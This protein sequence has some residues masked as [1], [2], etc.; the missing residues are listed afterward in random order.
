MDQAD[1]EHTK[2]FEQK[3]REAHDSAVPPIDPSV[4][5]PRPEFSKPSVKTL[6]K[7]EKVLLATGA[8]GSLGLGAVVIASL[9]ADDSPELAAPRLPTPS[10]DALPVIEGDGDTAAAP[11]ASASPSLAPT[12]A[13][14]ATAPPPAHHTRPVTHH[15]QAAPHDES[16]HSLRQIPDLVPVAQTVTDEMSYGQALSAAR[17]E[18][19]PGGLFVWNDTYYG[20]F[21]ESEWANLPASQQEKWLTASETVMQPAW[22]EPMAAD[23]YVV[24]AE[25]GDIVWTG[26]DKDGDGI[27]EVLI[28]QAG[29]ESPI[30]MMDTDGDGQLDTRYSL[31]AGSGEVV[32]SALE[33]SAFTMAEITKIPA[34]EKGS[35]FGAAS[36]E[37]TATSEAVPVAIVNENGSYLVGIDLDQDALVDVISLRHPGSV[38]FV[39]LDLDNDGQVEM[40]F[41][42]DPTQQ[43]VVA[44]EIE[45][46]APMTV[47][48]EEDDTPLQ[49]SYLDHES[50]N[51]G[52]FPLADDEAED[53]LAAGKNR[54]DFFALNADEP[55]FS[56]ETETDYDGLV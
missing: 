9:P 48:D 40:S 34:M 28:A 49:F 45:P 36:Y 29:D 19:G 24:V 8:L 10:P 26:I 3:S 47:A 27:A 33:P 55:L 42:Y 2:I 11:L 30:V 1:F 43:A 32:A 53:Q 15:P 21:T 50:I 20:T 31:S 37:G 44:V 4:S 41:L 14:S 35:L 38:P 18:V 12:S 17:A 6:T 23:E 13:P 5:V 39:A 7:Q 25:R 22:P 56:T 54:D 16:Y 51:D 52:T 46:L